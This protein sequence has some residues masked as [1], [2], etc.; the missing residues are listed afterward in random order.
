[1]AWRCA[2][3]ILDHRW[4]E[5]CDP[6][7]NLA[8][9]GATSDN[10]EPETYTDFDRQADSG[11]RSRLL[12]LVLF[13]GE[14]TSSRRNSVGLFARRRDVLDVASSSNVRDKRTE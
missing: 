12:S 10:S 11:R 14:D 9:G 13:F 5:D 7:S 8:L 3:G 6:L 4:L 1:M 2:V